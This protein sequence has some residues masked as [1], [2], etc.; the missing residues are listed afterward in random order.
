MGRP[1][2]D[3][4]P[5]VVRLPEGTAERIDTLVG[6]RTRAEFIRK[7]IEKELLRCERQARKVPD[8][9]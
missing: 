4:K 9:A 5:T 7:A 1:R 8:K 3:M 6:N 2:L